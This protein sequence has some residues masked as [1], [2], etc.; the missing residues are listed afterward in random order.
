MLHVLHAT[1]WPSMTR[2][3][4]AQPVVDAVAWIKTD[5]QPLMAKIRGLNDAHARQRLW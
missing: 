1:A 3:A 2:R 5:R 4:G